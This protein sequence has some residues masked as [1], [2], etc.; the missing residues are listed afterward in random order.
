MWGASITQTVIS[1]HALPFFKDVYHINEFEQMLMLSI[2]MLGVMTSCPFSG[3]V[4]DNY[5]R[6]RAC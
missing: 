3:Y 4:S 6:Y 2:Y 5:G 1:G